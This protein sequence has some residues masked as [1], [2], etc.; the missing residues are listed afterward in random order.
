MWQHFADEEN[1]ITTAR[2]RLAHEL[3]S[4][5]IA[6]HFGGVHQR[7]AKVEAETKRGHLGVFFARILA[8]LPRSLAENR[9]T[10]TTGELNESDSHDDG[11]SS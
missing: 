4:G 11:R 3:L 5:P 8:Q 9:D 2:N 6:V 7:H 10:F 1:L